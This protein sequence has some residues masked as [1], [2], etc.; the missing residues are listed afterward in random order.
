MQSSV[1]ARCHLLQNQAC[2]CHITVLH[3]VNGSLMP[4]AARC[5]VNNNNG[6][7]NDYRLRTDESATALSSILVRRTSTDRPEYCR[8]RRTWAIEDIRKSAQLSDQT[9]KRWQVTK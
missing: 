3:N 2:C 6:Q 7:T 4:L 1:I 5:E 9:C 8:Q